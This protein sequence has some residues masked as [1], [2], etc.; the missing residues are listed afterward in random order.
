[1]SFQQKSSHQTHE[2]IVF[3]ADGAIIKEMLYTEFE[4]LLDCVVPMREFV[5]R[6]MQAAYVRVD[7][8]LAVVATVL[9][10]AP[11]D[12]RGFPEQSWNVPLRQLAETAARGPDLGGGPV[13]LATRS[14]CPIPGQ[15][16]SLWDIEFGVGGN[17][18]SQL[19][20]KLH[21]NRL[22]I[23]AVDH[24]PQLPGAVITGAVPVV[25]GVAPGMAVAGAPT[26]E[27]A[28]AM[29]AFM[30]QSNQQVALLRKQH[31]QELAGTG[32]RLSALQGQVQVLLN[33]K[34][35]LSEQLAEQAA[36][37][38]DERAAAARALQ[39]LT[40]LGR[41]QT[42]AIRA[43]MQ[44]ARDAALAESAQQSLV[45]RERLGRELQAAEEQL[46]G[47][48]TELTDLRRDKMR[49][50]SDGAD[51]FFDALKEKGVKFVAYQPG[52]GH[53]TIAM[54]D[55]S[56][57]IEDTENFVAEKCAVSVEHYRR[58]LAHYTSPVCQGS[59]GDGGP[60]AKPLTRLL[61]PAEFVSG[62]HDRCDVHKQMPRTVP[63]K[64]Q[65]V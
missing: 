17:T 55:L 63:P 59:A 20:E 35:V 13:R 19:R 42:A 15:E 9:F 48:R 29:L 40:E 28:D 32:E 37:V 33:E 53:L 18:L 27:S 26:A 49:L 36:A 61:K 34:G 7:S 16:D 10:Y 8:A 31:R 57:Y 62:M 64:E 11:F 44:A 41:S 65:A 30:Q 50:M 4:A 54:E 46:Q 56:R 60:C 1:M 21:G 25:S 12:E 2:A 47:L 5:G 43:E 22:G 51:K 14:Q 6:N 52:A 23:D 39:Q 45:E 3:F 38:A 58:W 24:S